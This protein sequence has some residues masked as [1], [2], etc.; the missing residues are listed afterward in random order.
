MSTCNC[1]EKAKNR[2]AMHPSFS[3]YLLHFFLYT[4]IYLKYMYFIPLFLFLFGFGLNLSICLSVC[5]VCMSTQCSLSLCVRVLWYDC[6]A[7]EWGESYQVPSA[8]WSFDMCQERGMKHF[9]LLMIYMYIWYAWCTCTVY[10][11]LGSLLLNSCI[12]LYK[13]CSLL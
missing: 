5:H 9:D 3:F 13:P 10:L 12:M 1:K 6:R 4:S 11:L 8:N 2:C 7:S